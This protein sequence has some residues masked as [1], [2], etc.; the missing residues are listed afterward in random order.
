MPRSLVARL[1]LLVA[2]ITGIS[3]VLLVSIWLRST[4]LAYVRT[5]EVLGPQTGRDALQARV[6]EAARTALLRDG[7]RGLAVLAGAP[8]QA[9]LPADIA[10]LV[11]DAELAVVASTESLLQE[12]TVSEGPPGMLTI[13]AGGAGRS[14]TA[15]LQ[16]SAPR[17]AELRDAAGEVR[18]RLLLLPGPLDE[19]P[20]DH[21]ARGVWRSAAIWLI[22][23]IAISMLLT[24]LALRWFLRPIDR[25]TTAARA[26]VDGRQPEP[27]ALSGHSEIDRLI[28]AFNAASA[29][30]AKTEGLRRQLI[31]DIAHELRTPVT[32]L[33]AQIE[34]AG[35]GL[36]NNDAELLG[37]LGGEVE[38]LVELVE[39]FQQLA[40]S[41]AGQLRLSLESLPLAGTIASIVV[42][43]AERIGAEVELDIPVELQVQAD[44]HR[45]RQ[46]LANLVEN[47][48][49]H[50]PEGLRL[51]IRAEQIDSGIRISFADNGP[52]IAAVDLP[53]VFERFYRAEK[54]RNRASGGAGLGLTIARAL[55]EAMQGQMRCR[56]T[57]G[58]G[59]L[60]EFELPSAA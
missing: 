39:D 24:A 10:F 3:F 34:A 1:S 18:A 59:A 13:S 14:G 37:T 12:A 43:M 52:G 11:L 48:V 55:I 6:L 21:F 15:E 49:R 53:H 22:A 38:M 25:L 54:S 58:Q 28:G 17:G 50:R 35:A 7:Q 47:S 29:A 20:G 31:S 56:P 30:I 60:F 27:M 57:S 41:D 26:M 46:V 32:N 9:G 8:K 19:D 23:V 16:L 42:P 33:K 44:H 36:I 5:T 4:S 51:S 40:L 2:L 45:L